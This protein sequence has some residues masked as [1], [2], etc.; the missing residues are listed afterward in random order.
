MNRLEHFKKKE[1][2]AVFCP[3]GQISFDEMAGLVSRAVLLCRKQ[4][5]KK[6]LVDST[7]AHGF[8]PQGMAERYNLAER[9]ASD[10]AAAVK[11][12]HVASREWFRLGKFGV[13]VARNRGLDAGLFHSEATALE[14]LLKPKRVSKVEKASHGR[15]EV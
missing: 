4:K 6:L 7:G 5:I 9:I 1:G 8:G 12:A 13:E 2:Y 14:W 10:A 11:I 15:A 3:A